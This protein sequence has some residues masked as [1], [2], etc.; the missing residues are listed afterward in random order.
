MAII[1]S[2]LPEYDREMASTRKVL[3]RVPEGRFDWTPHPRSMSLGQL[4]LHLARLPSWGHMAM[5][6]SELDLSGPFAPPVA[7]SSDELLRTFDKE[8]GQTRNALAAATD[9]Q[10]MAPWSLKRDGK[11]V[12]TMPKAAVLRSFVLNH[13]IHHRGQLTVYLRLNDVALPSIYGPSADE[14]PL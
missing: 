8:S 11:T 3:E 7:A 12:F 10:L 13:I 9:A 4:A 6:R 1:D 5:D 2:L 14:A